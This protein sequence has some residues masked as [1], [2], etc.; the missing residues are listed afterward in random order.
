MSSAQL[1]NWCVHVHES[2]CGSI[3]H[4][5]LEPKYFGV[6]LWLQFRR[7]VVWPSVLHFWSLSKGWRMFCF[8]Y[9]HWSHVMGLLPTKRHSSVVPFHCCLSEFLESRAI[10]G[11]CL[12]S[13]TPW[14]IVN[15]C[16]EVRVR[17]FRLPTAHIPLCLFCWSFFSHA[18][19]RLGALRLHFTKCSSKLSNQFRHLLEPVIFEKGHN[20]PKGLVGFSQLKMFLIFSQA[21]LRGPVVLTEIAGVCNHLSHAQP[22]LGAAAGVVSHTAQQPKPPRSIGVVS[23]LWKQRPQK[24]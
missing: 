4:P 6:P 1:H 14:A 10:I 13:M 24:L 23:D 9:W 8:N 22:L 18:F 3:F 7:S 2:K 11:F 19:V 15:I 16:P 17:N 12:F 5:A 20:G 21:M